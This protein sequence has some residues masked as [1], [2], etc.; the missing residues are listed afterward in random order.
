MTDKKIT[1]SNRDFDFMLVRIEQSSLKRFVEKMKAIKE[2]KWDDE[3]IERYNN[4]VKACN[5]DEY[6]ATNTR[7]SNQHPRPNN[8]NRH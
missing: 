1:L 5:E 3:K 4:A 6:N 8:S 2:I 7:G